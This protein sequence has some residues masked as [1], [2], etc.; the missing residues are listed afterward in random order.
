MTRSMPTGDRCRTRCPVE[1]GSTRSALIAAAFD[2]EFGVRHS[3]QRI[4]V[5]PHRDGRFSDGLAAS[6]APH[7][8]AADRVEL[9]AH[10][11]EGLS[12]Y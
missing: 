6:R 12:A 7:V 3:A 10:Q 5:S 11:I 9:L 8:Q 2:V 1:R 4:G